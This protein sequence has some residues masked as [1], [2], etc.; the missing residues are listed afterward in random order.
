[1]FKIFVSFRLYDLL[2]FHQHMAQYLS[3]S[4][5]RDLRLLM[6]ASAMVTNVDIG[7]TSLSIHSLTQVCTTCYVRRKTCMLVKLNKFVCLN[8]TKFLAF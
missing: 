3:N 8:F 7:V 5:L 2:K 6:S 4:V 1:M